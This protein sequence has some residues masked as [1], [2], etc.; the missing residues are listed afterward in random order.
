MTSKKE[1][2]DLLTRLVSAGRG[3][4]LSPGEE[5]FPPGVYMKPPARF[6]Q[7]RREMQG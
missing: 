7:R 1:P 6:G 3:L 2:V 4:S 5:L